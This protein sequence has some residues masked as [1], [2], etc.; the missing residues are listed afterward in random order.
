[1]KPMNAKL[2]INYKKIQFVYYFFKSHSKLKKKIKDQIRVHLKPVITVDINFCYFNIFVVVGH[3]DL[4]VV[5]EFP[6]VE[7]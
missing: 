6:C 4:A 5:R 1:M 3:C 2:R 7:N